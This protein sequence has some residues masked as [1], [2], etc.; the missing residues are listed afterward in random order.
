[1]PS[2]AIR[3]LTVFRKLLVGAMIAAAGA[4]LAFGPR[5]G[6]MLPKDCVIVDYWEKWTG[7]EEV[8]M[9]QIV[10][11]FNSTVGRQKHIY[12]RYLSTSGIEQK[13]LVAAAAGAPPDVAGLYNQDIPQFGALDSLEPLDELA[14]R[15]G[16]TAQ[17]Y[18]KVYWDEFQY[19]GHLYGLVSS[20]Y[21]LALYYNKTIFRDRASSLLAAGLDPSRPPRSIPELDQY[22]SALNEIDPS[23]RILFAGYAPLEPG[24]YTGYTCFWF[25]GRWWDE[26]THRFTFTDPKVV[27][28]FQWIQSYYKR[29]GSQQLAQFQSGFGAF[30]SPQNA[31]LAPILAM[32]QQGTFFAQFIH[33]LKPSMDHQ[34]A[35]A[36]FPSFDPNLKEVTYCNCDVLTIPRGAKHPE[37]AFE[38]IAFVNRQDEMEKLANLHCK[39]SPLARVSPEFLLH[40]NNPYIK[41]FDELAASPNAHPTEPIPILPE[42][43]DEL[44][45]FTQQLSLLQVT[46]EAGLERLQARLQQKYDEFMEDQRQRRLQAQ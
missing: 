42:V 25:G 28:A 6:D 39:I 32:E 43:N 18:K 21:D 3:P 13:T 36:P 22:A 8:A 37:E 23:G 46:P 34:W 10:D 44:N 29:L 45:D 27:R 5:A 19:N 41:V 30:A 35:A 33:N 26:K 24:W 20:A 15:H 2:F 31:F 38:F 17:Q 4:L 12:V 16:I 9:R 40:H 1:M 7:D 11:D 14:A